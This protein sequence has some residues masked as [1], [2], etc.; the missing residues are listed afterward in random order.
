PREAVRAWAAERNLSFIEDTSNQDLR[1]DRNFLRHEILPR[2][3]Q[4]WPGIAGTL[5]RAARIQAQ[6]AEGLAREAEADAGWSEDGTLD[7]ASL[8][9]LPPERR[10]NVLRAWLRHQGLPPPGPERLG[11][12]FR[13]VVEARADRT[14][15]VRWAGAEVRRYRDRLYSSAPLAGRDPWRVIP[16][17]LGEPLRIAHCLL[18]AA[19]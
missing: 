13:E 11:Q 14:P 8:R 18:A 17:W 15:C 2:L 4:R 19:E 5:A 1:F 7:V 10:G 9:E 3:R 6:A 16:W 12:L